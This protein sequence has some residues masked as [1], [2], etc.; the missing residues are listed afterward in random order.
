MVIF[1]VI[2]H[3][4]YMKSILLILVWGYKVSTKIVPFCSMLPYKLSIH[5]FSYDFWKDFIKS[6]MFLVLSEQ[7]LTQRI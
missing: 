7:P 6:K 2:I 1:L 4:K 5:M 3:M